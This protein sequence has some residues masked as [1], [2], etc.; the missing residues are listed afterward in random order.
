MWFA[1]P[2]HL[3]VP[4]KEWLN[5]LGKVPEVHKRGLLEPLKVG[6]SFDCERWPVSNKMNIFY[7]L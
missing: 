2:L 4:H 5:N 7:C 3:K 1:F 6:E